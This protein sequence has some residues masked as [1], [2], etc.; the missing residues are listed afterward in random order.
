MS[1]DD[2]FGIIED[3]LNKC[4]KLN[5]LGF[6]PKARIREGLRGALKGYYP[7]SLDKLQTENRGLYERLV[8][9]RD[10]KYC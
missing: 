6:Y 9:K 1:R 5:R 2:A 4:D 10:K 7:M 3:W 8:I